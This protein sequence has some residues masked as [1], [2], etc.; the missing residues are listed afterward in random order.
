M[1]ITLS[2]L[3]GICQS[4]AEVWLTGVAPLGTVNHRFNFL[5]IL[6]TTLSGH[7]SPRNFRLNSSSEISTLAGRIVSQN[8]CGENGSEGVT[9]GASDRFLLNKLLLINLLFVYVLQTSSTIAL[10]GTNVPIIP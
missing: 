6:T 7:T 10:T 4:A 9:A 8:A 3:T 5:F 2:H 1:L